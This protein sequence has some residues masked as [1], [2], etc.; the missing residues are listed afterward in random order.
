MVFAGTNDELLFL[1]KSVINRQPNKN[2][3]LF[4][5]IPHPPGKTDME[6]LKK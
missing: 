3:N 2:I 5:K 6:R 4:S 1:L